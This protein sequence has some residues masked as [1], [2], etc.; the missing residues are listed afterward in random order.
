[1]PAC[2]HTLTHSLTHTLTYSHTTHT[3]SLTH[4]LTHSLIH[5]THTHSLTHSLNSLTH[6]THTHSL[7]HNH[8]ITH[9]RTAEDFVFDP[10]SLELNATQSTECVDVGIVRDG[11]YEIPENFSIELNAPAD[12]VVA[13]GTTVIT[14]LD[15]DSKCLCWRMP[16]PA[17]LPS[18]LCVCPIHTRPSS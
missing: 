13:I 3:H 6:N 14:I 11:I 8:T 17:C 12:V 7:T 16:V 18:R 5:N 1:M 9:A 4:P 15:S 2:T 10:L